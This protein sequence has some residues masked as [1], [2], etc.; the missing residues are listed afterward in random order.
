MKKLSFFFLV[1]GISLFV[2]CGPSKKEK[3]AALEKARQDSIKAA[4]EAQR[5]ADSIAAVQE[6]QRIQD[7]IN[8]AIQKAKEDSIAALEKKGKKKK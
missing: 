2:A 1:A 4:E 7:S 3:E 5:Q 8:A 6:Q